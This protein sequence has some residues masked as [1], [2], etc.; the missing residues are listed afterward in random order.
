MLCPLHCR[1]VGINVDQVYL[2]TATVSLITAL[3]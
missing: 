2:G 1:N 3:H